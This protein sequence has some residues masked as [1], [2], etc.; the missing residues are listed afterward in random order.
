VIE[1]LVHGYGRHAEAVLEMAHRTPE[2]MTR[3][4]RGAPVVYGQFLYGVEQELAETPGDLLDR[5]TELGARGLTDQ[6]ARTLAAR[7][8]RT[9]AGV[10]AG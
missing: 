7:A 2:G 3:V 10:S 6:N 8:L 5:R 9:R 1:H 4:V